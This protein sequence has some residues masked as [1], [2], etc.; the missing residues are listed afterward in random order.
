MLAASAAAIAA[1]VLGFAGAPASATRTTAK[2]AVSARLVVAQ[3]NTLRR[4]FGLGAGRPT[5][6]FNA[7][8]L[9]GVRTNGDPPFAPIAGG[10]VGEDSVWGLLATSSS[11]PTAALP[12]VS[13]WVFHDGWQ[14]SAGATWNLD[15]T[16]PS[17]PGCNGH[18]RAVL[19]TPPVPGAKL[20]IDATTIGSTGIDGP[21]V[22]VAVLL[23]WRLPG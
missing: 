3:I 8:V 21:G 17:A 18:R 6:A 19:S 11:A 20:Y 1:I 13:D 4:E 12:I 14:G 22:A 15:C 2:S 5:T 9:Q 7:E 10:I 23:V 16:T